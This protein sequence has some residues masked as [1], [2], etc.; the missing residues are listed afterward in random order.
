MA[1]IASTTIARI[2]GVKLLR[3]GTLSV[4]I[5]LTDWWRLYLRL[6]LGLFLVWCA[7]RVLGCGFERKDEEDD[8][9]ARST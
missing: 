1:S 4:K 8:T 3:Q 6:R 5:E 2:S 9:G 7:S